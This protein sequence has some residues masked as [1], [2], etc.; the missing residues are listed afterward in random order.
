MSC[1]SRHTPFDKVRVVILGQD[2]YHGPN[3]AHGMCFSVRPPTKAPPSLLNIYK[4]IKEDYPDFKPPP[5]NGGLLTP[6]ADR[7]VLLLNTCLT[8]RAGSAYS[9]NQKGWERLT[10][11]VIDI[12]NKKSTKGVVFM[13]WGNPAKK[14]CTKVNKELHC[15]LQS[16]HPSPLANKTGA[17]VRSIPFCLPLSWQNYRYVGLHQGTNIS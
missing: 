4:A 17:F 10:G 8:V 3:Q 16:I 15:I 6:W 7:G 14:A 9:H 12:V 5:N 2:P 1:R 13:A 11:K